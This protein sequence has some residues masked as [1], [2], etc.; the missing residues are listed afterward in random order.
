MR[1]GA[2]ASADKKAEDR[3]KGDDRG[4]EQQGK[5]HIQSRLISV[6]LLISR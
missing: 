4:I 5:K 1:V 2:N 6:A 3:R